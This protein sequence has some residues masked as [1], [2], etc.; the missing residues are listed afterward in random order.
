MDTAIQQLFAEFELDDETSRILAATKLALLMEM[1]RRP[2]CCVEGRDTFYTEW[3][4]PGLL[5][6]Q[7][8]PEDE[9]ELVGKV[10]ERLIRDPCCSGL[11]GAL[12]HADKWI[13][14]RPFMD[15]VC[16]RAQSWKSHE[17]MN[18]ACTLY[19]FFHKRPDEKWKTEGQ[20][21]LQA[22]DLSRLIQAYRDADD[23]AVIEQ[24]EGLGW[25]FGNY[26][27]NV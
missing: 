21:I 9:L 27:D 7:L 25:A 17:L 12:R 26:I 14:A 2:K 8:S 23:P 16:R 20:S 22:Y 18:I 15:V 13:A 6:A 4:S 3:L 5:A 10:A 19:E 11:E 24:A 1:L